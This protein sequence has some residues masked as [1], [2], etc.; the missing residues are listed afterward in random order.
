MGENVTDPV[1]QL[2]ADVLAVPPASI[3]DE[4]CPE[5]TPQ[6]DSLKAMNLVAAIEETFAVELTT[7]EIMAMR[8]VGLVR[9]VLKKKRAITS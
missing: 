8:S 3:S 5:N 6:W 9:A 2:F 4:T 7:T 1:Y